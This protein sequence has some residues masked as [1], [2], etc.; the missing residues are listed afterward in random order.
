MAATPVVV[1]TVKTSSS[2]STNGD[3]YELVIP[4]I[5]AVHPM[6][7]KPF[8]LPAVPSV[9]FTPTGPSI[10]YPNLNADEDLLRKVVD[11]TWRSLKDDWLQ[12]YYFD[13]YKLLTNKNGSVQLIQSEK[14]YDSNRS[15]FDEAKYKYIL[16]FVIDKSDIA[17]LVKKFA[18]KMRLDLWDVSKN[19]S[20][21]RKFVHKR[22]RNYIKSEIKAAASH[23]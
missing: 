14:E 2:G 11:E 23:R 22:I 17:R 15:E 4:G 12:Y 19:K 13:L 16:D 8:A 7:M 21:L 5:T 1:T 10:V 9:A 3:G 6:A 18:N 20:S